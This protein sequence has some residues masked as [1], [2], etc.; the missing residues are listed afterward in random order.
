M[1]LNANYTQY[2]NHAHEHLQAVSV[3]KSSSYEDANRF[4]AGEGINIE[5]G[6]QGPSC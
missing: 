1:L 5:A 4:I 6:N 2:Q 3:M